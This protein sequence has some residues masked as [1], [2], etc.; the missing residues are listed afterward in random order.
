MPGFTSIPLW[1]AAWNFH[2]VLILV[3]SDQT[4]VC[5]Y[6]TLT[7]RVSSTPQNIER[8]PVHTC[9]LTA[10]FTLTDSQRLLS[11]VIF[12]YNVCPCAWRKRVHLVL[13]CVI[14]HVIIPVQRELGSVILMCFTLEPQNVINAQ[15]H[16]KNYFCAGELEFRMKSLSK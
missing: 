14:E 11:R 3:D 12:A 2:V 13:G 16:F 1:A 4:T 8:I 9:Y 7:G 6:G 15:N 5:N 10:N